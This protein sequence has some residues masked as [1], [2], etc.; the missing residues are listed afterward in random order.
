MPQNPYLVFALLASVFWAI[1]N[2]MD[3]NILK[4]HIQNPKMTVFFTSVFAALLSLIIPFSGFSIAT[5]LRLIILSMVI[6]VV[7]ISA[8]FLYM[9]ALSLEE[10]SRIAPVM[11]ISP[12]F[13]VILGAFFLN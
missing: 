11:S 12:V 2:I 13:V 1:T 8:T 10:V 5:S 7:Y 6:G 9:K 3:K 4:N